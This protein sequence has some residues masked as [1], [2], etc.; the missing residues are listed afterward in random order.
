MTTMSMAE[1]QEKLAKAK[2]TVVEA[3]EAFQ[4]HKKRCPTCKC[5]GRCQKRQDMLFEVGQLH[6]MVSM[7]E[8]W[9]NGYRERQGRGI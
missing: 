3:Y 7:V 6:M 9:L 5:G 4:V 8:V 2:A 1:V